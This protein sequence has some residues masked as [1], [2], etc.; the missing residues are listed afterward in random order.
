[1]TVAAMTGI[2]ATIG[3]M[4]VRNHIRS[5]KMTEGAANVQAVRVG[6]EGVRAETGGYVNCSSSQSAWY[7]GTPGPQVY[8]WRNPGHADWNNWKHLPVA[9]PNGTRF[10]F[11]LHAGRASEKPPTTVLSEKPT[12]T[13]TADP[14]YVIQAAADSDG[15]GTYALLVATSFNGEVF[16]EN[17]EE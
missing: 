17:E 2:L 11:L 3:V 10:G 13:P 6:Q 9:I 7:P 1:M 16:V 8:A 14:W 12:W 15:D 5:A 4:L